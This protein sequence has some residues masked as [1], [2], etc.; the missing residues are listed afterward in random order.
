MKYW[1]VK[2]EPSCYSIEDFERDKKTEWSGVRNYQARNYMRDMEK[3]DLVLF[4]HSSCADVGV[5]GIAKVLT[6]AHPDVTAFDAKDDHYDPKSTKEKS[7]W[8]C[9]TI[10]FVEKFP[11]TITL[12]E[13][14]TDAS[15]SGM[16]LIQKGSRLS[17]HAVSE[18]HFNSIKKKIKPAS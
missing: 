10:G 11:R 6:R 5:V 2:S 17:V 12:T 3:G 14:K 7:I 8:D 18:K 15:L 1:L 9:V 16:T 4:Y 13:I